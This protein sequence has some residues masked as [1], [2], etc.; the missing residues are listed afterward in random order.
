MGEQPARL[1]SSSGRPSSTP[2]AL[3]AVNLPRQARDLTRTDATPEHGPRDMSRS[4]SRT[5]TRI[6]SRLLPHSR[7]IPYP[8]A[9]RSCATRPATPDFPFLR[10]SAPAPRILK[11]TRPVA[12]PRLS[13]AS[14]ALQALLPWGTIRDPDSS[15][16]EGAVPGSPVRRS[17][18][19]PLS[20]GTGRQSRRPGG[21]R[22]RRSRNPP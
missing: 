15:H 22:W 17:Q 6:R 18:N 16:R 5:A 20:N 8:S 21:T 7:A 12:L 13:F 3:F 1:G 14:P 10:S 4:L 11:L 2:A 19:T 9:N